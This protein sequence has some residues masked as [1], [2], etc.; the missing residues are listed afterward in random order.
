MKVYTVGQVNKILKDYIERNEIL[1]NI[2]VEGEISNV[3]YQEKHMYMTLKDKN[4]SI[5]CAAFFY[6]FNEIPKDLKEGDKVKIYGS[7]NVYDVD[8]SVQIV[9]KKIEKSNLLGDLY[10]KLELLK[11]EYQNKGY[12]DEC[13]K[14]KLPKVPRCIGIVT[15]ETGDAVRDII[16]NAH[17][18]DEKVSIYLYPAKVQ[19]KDAEKT[20]A[21]GIKF[22]NLH[23]ELK[24][25]CIIIG[26]GGGSIEDLWPF[27]EKEVVEAIHNSKL[28]IISAVGHEADVLL[29]DYV[30]DKRVSTPTQAAHE[31]IANRSEIDKYL[32]EQNKKLS[33]L[34][35]QKIEIMKTKLE[36]LKSNYY[37]YKFYDNFI[38]SKYQLLDSKN[39]ELNKLAK[40]NLDLNIKK[41]KLDNLNNRLEYLIIRILEN[42]KNNLE[43]Y[44]LRLKNYNIE[45]FLNKGF[46]ITTINGHLIK[47][48]KVKKGDILNTKYKNGDIIS[49]VK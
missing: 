48:I 35:L 33:N 30:A 25:E 45:D 4:V 28:P 46:S 41:E 12:F 29:S 1:R 19:G 17:I 6:K 14:K 37:I 36:N 21:L 44:R 9:T 42:K 47:D 43:N 7:I 24:V 38:L 5:R 13:L 34:L 11:K 3:K 16:K 2:C 49:E 8:A 23:P 31:I 39:I 18:R 22:F 20:I 26:R 27:N 10:E 15:S 32:L 40:S